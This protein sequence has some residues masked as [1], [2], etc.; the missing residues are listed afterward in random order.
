MAT[1]HMAPY[2]GD[3]EGHNYPMKGDKSMKRR[4][5]ADELRELRNKIPIDR[6]IEDVLSI[7]AKR[8]EGFLRF[9]CPICNEFQTAVKPATNLA[10]CF[11][12]QKN[13]NT[14]ELTMQIKNMGFVQTATYLTDI[15]HTNRRLPE[16]L[17]GV[18]SQMNTA[19]P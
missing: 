9:L 4:F 15:L 19:R 11:R 7:P 18:A 17:S 2:R 12:C 8:S 5:S 14:I 10:R 1:G 13:F 3:G 16:L 6:L